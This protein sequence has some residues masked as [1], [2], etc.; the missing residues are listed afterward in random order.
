MGIKALMYGWEFP[1]HISGG[2]GV[3]C[4]AIVKELAKRNI[5]ITLILPRAASDSGIDHVDLIGCDSLN[6][7]DVSEFDGIVDIKYPEVA[8]YLSP[9]IAAKDFKRFLCNETLQDFFALLDKM[10]LPEELKAMVAAT[11][12]AQ[13][14]DAQITGKYD[15]DLLVEVFRYALVAGALAKDVEYDVIHAHDWL[16]VLA[17][18]EAKRFSHKPLVLHVHALETDRS[19]SRIDKRVFAI[20]KYGM[21]QADQIIAVSQ[22]TKNNIIQHYGVAS[23]KISVVHNGVYCNGGNSDITSVVKKESQPKMVLFL[24]RL[25]QQKGPYFF[26]EV[27]RRVLEKRADV[28]FVLAGA[29]DLLVEMIERTASLRIGQNVHFTG[30][31]DSNRVQEIYRIA[32]VYVMPSISEPFGLSALEAISYNVPT[33]ITKQ[34]GVSEVLRH[35]L[36]SDFWDVEDMAAKILV[37]LKYPVL[38]CA[39]LANEQ[40]ELQ[41]TTWGKTAEKIIEIYKRMI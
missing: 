11:A 40:K 9:Y 13:G 32:D 18:L 26:I 36:V 17:A 3:A 6:S 41:V 34:S 28:Q 4:Y 7:A 33:I 22:Y 16:T 23:E 8:T 25:T 5:D 20:E 31:L 15:I 10:H 12:E 2:L 27:A 38:R 35:T 14:P 29:G 24:G 30:F 21:N 19:G 37:L 39:S 1:P